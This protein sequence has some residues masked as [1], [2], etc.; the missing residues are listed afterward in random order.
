MH[1][2]N[3]RL[4]LKSEAEKHFYLDSLTLLRED[5]HCARERGSAV[6]SSEEQLLPLVPKLIPSSLPSKH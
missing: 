4:V 5:R 2:I 3:T 6:E 1:S